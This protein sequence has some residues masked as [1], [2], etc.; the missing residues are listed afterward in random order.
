MAF[1]PLRVYLITAVARALRGAPSRRKYTRKFLEERTVDSHALSTS[2]SARVLG[3]LGACL[4]S[5]AAAQAGAAEVIA[6]GL[7]NPRGIAF[8]ASGGLYVA[9]N[10]SGGEGPC[11]PSP[12]SPLPRCYG[13]TGAIA[14]IL[15]EGG[16]RRIIEGLPSLALPNGTAEG[17]PARISFQGN[18]AYLTMGWGG[19]PGGRAALG[20][21]AELFGKMLMVTP[22]GAWKIVADV[23]AHESRE[24]PAGG[25]VDTNPYGLVALPGRRVVADAGANALVEVLANGRTRTLAVPPALPPAPPSPGPRETVPTSVAEGPDG[26]LYVGLLT[27]FPF[28]KGTASVLRVSSD[29]ASIEDYATGFTAI[30]DVA[31]D[32]GGALYVLE[33]ATGQSTPFPPPAPGLGIG[34]L[35]RQCPHGERDVLLDGLSYPGGLA[36]GPDGAVYLTNNGTSATDGEVLRVVVVPCM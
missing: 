12:A 27:A 14:R 31:F 7:S 8:S 28:W 16:F 23:A 5:G 3:I 30:S 20:G 36:I 11:I 2:K 26:A 18:V 19:D 6:S 4:L 9:E 25:A 10:G 1:R 35:V 32:A 15:P 17:G 22:S 34:R 21:R 13:E 29:G 24:N 33:T